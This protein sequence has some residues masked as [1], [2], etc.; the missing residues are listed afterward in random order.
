MDYTVN[1]DKLKFE[2]GQTQSC[3]NVSIV[4]D[5]DIEPAEIFTV[6]LL[7]TPDLDPRITLDPDTAR[8]EIVDRDGMLDVCH[9]VCC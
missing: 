3:T 2:V 8:V 1:A 6:N 7:E 5:D 4:K 9:L